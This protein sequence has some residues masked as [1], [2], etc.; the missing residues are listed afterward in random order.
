M[1]SFIT[2]QL[3]TIKGTGIVSYSQYKEHSFPHST[4]TLL[5]FQILLLMTSKRPAHIALVL[6][7]LIGFILLAT[8]KNIHKNRLL[9]VSFL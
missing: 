3:M 6:D 4:H 5:C 1:I 8:T 7:S 9:G 2:T